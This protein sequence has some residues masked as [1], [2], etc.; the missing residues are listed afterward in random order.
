MELFI[1][2]HFK[3]FFCGH[4]LRFKSIYSLLWTRTLRGAINSDEVRRI[5]SPRFKR[6]VYTPKR[7]IADVGLGQHLGLP[8]GTY[9]DVHD[10]DR[11][12]VSFFDCVTRR[13][14]L[15]N[16][17][18]ISNISLRNNNVQQYTIKVHKKIN[19]L[20]SLKFEDYFMRNHYTVYFFLHSAKNMVYYS[21]RRWR[22]R[23]TPSFCTQRLFFFICGKSLL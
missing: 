9:L 5:C 16:P 17:V 3:Q 23:R 20:K 15:F 1:Y 10:K 21:W 14:E 12:L 2:V 13:T 22:K 19:N 8:P 4:T 18:R 7:F 11:S 6:A